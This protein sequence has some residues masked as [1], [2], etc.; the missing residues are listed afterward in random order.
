[1]RRNFFNSLISGFITLDR[2]STA[3]GGGWLS[4]RGLNVTVHTAAAL[5]NCWLF[6]EHYFY[7]TPPPREI[8]STSLNRPN[9]MHK[10]LSALFLVLITAL[11]LCAQQTGPGG[12]EA[13]IATSNL[14]AQRIGP[15]DLLALQVYDAPEFTRTVR[16]SADG[17]I[18]LPMLKA[19]IRVQGLLP[20]E[21]SVL[22]AEALERDKLFVD[23]FVTVNVAEYH[24]RPISV[25]G[26]VRNPVIF[27][28]IGSVSLLDALAR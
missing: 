27:Q 11:T 28:A 20:D 22:V 21:V 8:I 1:M 12:T 10:Q 18:R 13:G 17:T 23:P 24:S 19:P 4:R 3:R 7:L 16:V 9:H 15:E 26:A 6:C 5:F 25:T 2:T 14:P